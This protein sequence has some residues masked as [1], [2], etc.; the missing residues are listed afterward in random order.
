MHQGC[1]KWPVEKKGKRFLLINNQH[2]NSNK[3]LRF[4]Y[5]C[6]NAAFSLDPLQLPTVRR[7]FTLLSFVRLHQW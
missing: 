7:Y 5:L 4:A 3:N 1:I 6:V 2:K